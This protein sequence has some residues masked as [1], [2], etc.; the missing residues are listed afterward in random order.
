MTTR[1]DILLKR[2]ADYPE[3]FTEDEGAELDRL[4]AELGEPKDKEPPPNPRR[5]EP[6]A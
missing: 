2:F 5:N 1:R 4:V 3:S 6:S